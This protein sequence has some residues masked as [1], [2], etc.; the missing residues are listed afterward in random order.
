[1][2]DPAPFT[3]AE[4]ALKCLI[5]FY[6]SHVVFLFLV[7]TME[8]SNPITDERPTTESSD[9]SLKR[10]A[11]IQSEAPSR[12]QSI[13]V[14]LLQTLVIAFLLLI[15]GVEIR[16]R[17]PG[18][19]SNTIHIIYIT[20]FTALATLI[21]SLTVVHLRKLWLARL[22]SNQDGTATFITKRASTIVGLSSLTESLNHWPIYMSFLITGLMTTAIVS[23]L[24]PTDFLG[25]LASS[26][27]P[28]TSL[29]LQS[30]LSDNCI[31][32]DQ[33]HSRSTRSLST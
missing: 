13:V 22:A 7:T 25:Q 6:A 16:L 14:I 8:K 15:I 33:S 11:T 24:T 1:M 28:S 27:L 4:C 2:A 19:L 10:S 3:A 26:I 21:T 5:P 17:H 31:F 30:Y 23:A 20:G 9:F 12:A 29:T 32:V 18:L